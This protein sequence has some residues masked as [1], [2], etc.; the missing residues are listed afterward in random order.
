MTITLTL[1]LTEES[2][3]KKEMIL[4]DSYLRTVI[5]PQ[6]KDLEPD[7]KNQMQEEAAKNAQINAEIYFNQESVYIATCSEQAVKENRQLKI[8]DFLVLKRLGLR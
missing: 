4:K 2:R 8:L 3:M 6:L 7:A 5:E 1:T